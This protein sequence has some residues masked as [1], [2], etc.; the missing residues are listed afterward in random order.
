MGKRAG[1]GCRGAGG[2]NGN[3]SRTKGASGER[4]LFSLLRD[5]LG[6]MDI[7][8]NLDQTRSGGADCTKLVGGFALEV[9]RWG[10]KAPLIAAIEQAEVQAV[11]VGGLPCVAF[12]MDH[13]HWRFLPVLSLEQFCELA[14][15]GTTARISERR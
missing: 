15:E 3:H 14:Q 9:K 7:Q 11:E 13:G 5:H 10:K 12:R 4:E 6:D 2:M 1:Q 8:R